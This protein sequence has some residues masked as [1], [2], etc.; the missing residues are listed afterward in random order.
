MA[1]FPFDQLYIHIIKHDIIMCVFAATQQF[2]K[3]LLLL[4]AYYA[5]VCSMTSIAVLDNS[6]CTISVV[7]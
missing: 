4:A 5:T 7:R 1:L 3:V 6:C 2:Y